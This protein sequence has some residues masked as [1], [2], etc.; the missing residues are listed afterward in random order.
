[1]LTPPLARVQILDKGERYEVR[2]KDP[3]DQSVLLGWSNDTEAFARNVH[4]HPEWHSRYIIDRNPGG[5]P[6]TM[7]VKEAL[8]HA[9]RLQR[10]PLGPGSA[11]NAVAAVTLADEVERLTAIVNTL[12]LNGDGDRITIGSEQSVNVPSY[13]WCAVV[14]EEL[15]RS[16]A[17]L[18]DG[19]GFRRY[20]FSDLFT[21]KPKDGA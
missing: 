12:P 3:Y 15:S 7:T 19:T 21:R 10:V 17:G 20:D 14:V 18:D 8:G 16:E 5:N 9:A 13:G 2:C 11:P 6:M 1:M 4:Q